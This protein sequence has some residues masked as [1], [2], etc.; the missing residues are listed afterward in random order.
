MGRKVM[1]FSYPPEKEAIIKKF[2]GLCGDL[3][4]PVSEGILELIEANVD[5]K[6]ELREKHNVAD[7]LQPRCV[8]SCC[9][10]NDEDGQCLLEKCGISV[11]PSFC[12]RNNE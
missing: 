4:I 10:K 11:K 9:W 6:G 12:P 3:G 1:S 8:E 5:G 2:K 7:A